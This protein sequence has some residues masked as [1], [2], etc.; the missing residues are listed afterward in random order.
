MFPLCPLLIKASLGGA[1]GPQ[2]RAAQSVV[3]RGPPVLASLGG[4]LKCRSILPDWHGASFP[5]LWSK[6][7]SSI[8]QTTNAGSHL[9]PFANSV[10]STQDSLHLLFRLSTHSSPRPGPEANFSRSPAPNFKSSPPPAQPV[11]LTPRLCSLHPQS[12]GG[13]C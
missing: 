10:P 1:Q 5:G 13:F 3:P 2:G 7:I 11:R 9:S 4:W 6:R 8:S 12:Q